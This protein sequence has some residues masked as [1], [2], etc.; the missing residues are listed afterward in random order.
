[1]TDL[2]DWWQ[3]HL[4]V[5]DALAPDADNQHATDR[6]VYAVRATLL[7]A[8]RRRPGG[9]QWFRP[10]VL[11]RPGQDLALLRDLAQALERPEQIALAYQPV[12]CLATGRTRAVEA[13]LRWTHPARGPVPALA[14]VAAA[15]RSGLVHRL[16]ALVLDQALAAAA[17]WR[18]QGSATTVHVNVSPVE[19]R[20]PGYAER[21]A[22]LLGRHAVPPAGLLLEVTETDVMTGD[23]DVLATLLRLRRLGVGIGID[24]FGTGYSSISHLHRLPVDTVKVDRS[25]IAGIAT[26][27]ADLDLVRAVLAL[28]ATAPVEVVVERALG[29]DLAQGYHLGRPGPVA[30]LDLGADRAP[31]AAWG[32]A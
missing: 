19:L 17:G 11:S 29:C 22:D 26:S 30:D 25:L 14:A 23:A 15:E 7:D 3:Q 2:A 4:P 27:P 8:A 16:G 1:M 6:N 20:D 24:D 32:V 31:G 21:V 18:R 28:L 12:R 9:V 10:E 5:I 13:L